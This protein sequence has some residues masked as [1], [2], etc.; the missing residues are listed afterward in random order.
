MALGNNGNAQESSGISESMKD[1]SDFCEQLKASL[2]GISSLLL[3]LDQNNSS[4]VSIANQTNLLALN[5]SIEAAR[6]GE[7]G[8]GF[9]VVATEIKNLAEGSKNTANDS[10]RNK[11]EI[12][13]SILQLLND[14]ENLI[15]IV[16]KVNDRTQNLAAVSEEIAA[17]ADIV[18]EISGMVR[19]KL[20]T[21][22]E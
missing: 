22:D 10:N 4:V 13:N 12:E 9:S 21:L 1:I 6:A 20:K 2:E 5:A 14:A 19:K 8:R 11:D 7:A 16:E 17:S 3:K 15:S 18:T